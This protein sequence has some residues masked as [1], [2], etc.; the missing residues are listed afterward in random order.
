M[1]RLVPIKGLDDTVR[2]CASLRDVELT[3]AGSGPEQEG[4]RTLAQ[5]MRQPV[6]LPGTLVR[7]AKTKAL[8]EADI[9]IQASRPTSRGREEGVPTGLLEAMAAELPIIATRT[10]G[11]TDI[12]HDGHNALLVEPNHPRQP[13]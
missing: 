8:A 7:E 11:I 3:C 1:S 2:A 13:T 4:L 5:R 10:G 12:L 9:F 6:R